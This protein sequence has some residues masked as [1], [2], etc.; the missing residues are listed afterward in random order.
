[1]DEL[2]HSHTRVMQTVD[3][4]PV[5]G[6]QAIIHTDAQGRVKGMTDRFIRDIAV[7]TR[8]ALADYQAVELAVDSEGGWDRVT[9]IPQVDLQVLRHQGDDYLTYR[10]RVDHF[11]A[12][13]EPSI[14]VIFINAEDGSEVWRYNDLHTSRNRRTYTASNGTSLPGTLR[15]SEGQ[16]ATG[17]TVLDQAHDN[18]GLTYDYY[19]NVH[20]RDSFSNAGATI[21][22]TVHYSSNY[23]NAFWN[24][25]QM[26]YGDGDG[27]QSGPLTVL[28]VV[29]H[30]LTHAVTDYESDLIYAN[31]SGALNEAMSD[32]FGAAVEVYR[33]GAISANTWKV[34]EECWTPATPGDALR[35]MN[36]PAQGGD[37]DHYPTRYTGSQD[38]GG[39]HWNSGI[40]NLAFYLLV[41]GGMHPRGKTTVVVPAIGMAKAEKIFYRA[42]ANYLTPSSNFQ[43]AR[44]ATAQAAADLYGQA[45]VD[46][47]H[48]AWDAVAVPGGGGGGGGTC[49]SGGNQ[50]TGSVSAGQSSYI[51][52]SAGA[53]SHV[54]NLEGPAGTDF[55]LYLQ[56]QSCYWIFCTWGDV[57]SSTS[58]SSIESVSYNG[59]AG[60]Y[61]WEVYAY[62][63][64]GSYTLCETH[65]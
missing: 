63:G 2:G 31:E 53:G 6:G 4:I 19:W 23:V 30:E 43:A 62:S 46:A 52:Y 41:Q 38:N 42:N 1:M 64:S 11:E 28:D 51:P 47:V 35:Y 9:G 14:Q 57:A 61:R 12:G 20:G 49:D 39:V 29:A 26:V 58:A 5:F 7:N 40:A 50:H 10:V 55:D 22:S 59:T 56:K 33:D 45:E 27:S 18:A 8:P 32:I 16:A 15:R 13:D 24:G 21:N 34:G 60:T 65:P 37:Y 36:D 17:D 25:S 44:N 3:N 48:A 54:A